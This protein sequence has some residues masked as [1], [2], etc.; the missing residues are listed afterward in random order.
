MKTHRLVWLSLVGVLV[1]WTSLGLA[2]Q[3]RYGGTLRIAWPG[4]PA[5]FDANQGPAQGAPAGWL[6]N[7][8]YNSLLKLTP[9]PELTI[10]PELAK[11]WEVLDE[12]KTYVFHLEEGVKFH[13]GTDFDAHV[14]K[15][16]IDR[17]LDPDVK[18]WVRPFYE[19]ID[20]VE[21]VDTYT[22]RVRM[23]EPSGALPRALAGYF[24]G[25]PMI[26]PTAFKQYGDDWKRHPIGTGPFMLKEWIP[27]EHVLLVKNPHYFKPGLPYLDA[28]EC[29]IMKD[30]LTA[31]T[32]LRAGEIDFLV[33]IP[34]QQVPILERSAGITVVTGPAM[35]PIVGFLNLRVTP[36]HDLRARRAIG[37]Y[38]IDR[39]EI[40]RVAFQGRAQPLVSVLAPGV[41]DAID[42]NEMYPYKPEEAKRLL[43]ELGYDAKHPL[44]FTILISNQDATMADI[45]ALIKNPMT[46]LGVEAKI[47]LLDD[48]AVVD[49]VLVRHDFDMVVSSWANLVDINQRSVSFFK[50]RQSDYMG[51][52][53]PQ[54]EDLVHQWRRAL[55]PEQRTAISAAMQRRLA[56]QLEWINLTTYPYFEAYR[57]TVKNFPFY[58]PTATP[59]F[60]MSTGAR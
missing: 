7:N 52:D 59:I 35:I 43:T 33:R 50:G 46:K 19:D 9:P 16:N 23:K 22:L 56:D 57:Q 5:F 30:P 1:L 60:D 32:A 48:P 36:F 54:L 10:V 41:P 37:G 4:D 13:D 11:S 25:I 38:G 8:M 3:P 18:A 47:T 39:T 34:L 21:V 6:M 42:L 12:G 14:A 24:Q 20:Q 2:E 44:H 17:I 26:S 51:I 31:T 49:R 45:A 55:E 29:R 58:N 27:G 28:L 15:W 40:A 53:D